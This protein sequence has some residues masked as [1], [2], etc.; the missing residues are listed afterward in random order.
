[1]FCFTRS[2]KSFEKTAPARSERT[3]TSASNAESN[4]VPARK[5]VSSASNL[6]YASPPFYPSGSSNKEINL[7][8]NKNAQVGS[9]S[10]NNA[11][12]QGKNLV[13]SINIDKV[14]IDK[15]TRPSVGKP[16]NNVHITPPGSSGVN[17]FHA[18]LPMAAGTGRGVAIPI[19]MNYQPAPSHNH[20]NKVSPGQ[21]QSVQR[22]YAPGRSSTSVQATAQQLGHRPSSRS[23]SSSPPKTTASFNSLDS[24]DMDAASESGK[25]KGAMIGKGKGG[26]QGTGQGSFV[27]GGAQVMGAAGN[28]GVSHR[29]P[30]FPATPTFLPGLCLHCLLFGNFGSNLL[31]QLLMFESNFLILK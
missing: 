16:S 2:G 25:T 19:Q 28:G 24:V 15:S 18:S 13:D 7:V 9:N 30:N 27:Y 20:V 23:Q 31:V 11:L 17:A 12:L 6:N 5:Q 3:S 21:L 4:P 10:K 26:S 8:Q 29:D 1:M 14:Y 22:S